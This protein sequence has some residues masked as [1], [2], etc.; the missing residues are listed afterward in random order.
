MCSNSGTSTSAR[1]DRTRE[2]YDEGFEVEGILWVV[3][4]IAVFCTAFQEF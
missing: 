2:F 1:P 3:G 4:L